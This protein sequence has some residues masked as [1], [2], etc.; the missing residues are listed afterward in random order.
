MCFLNEGKL[1]K[2]ESL[3]CGVSLQFP[4]IKELVI[5]VVWTISKRKNF[6]MWLTRN[7]I[8][9]RIIARKTLKVFSQKWVCDYPSRPGCVGWY[10]FLKPNLLAMAAVV[11]PMHATE[12]L[13][14]ESERR[15][16]QA[17]LQVKKSAG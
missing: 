13:Q 11:S 7:N 17:L 9:K 3:L 16:F 12:L 14:S 6:S 2:L 5:I 8:Q 4:K 10:T 15:F 1:L